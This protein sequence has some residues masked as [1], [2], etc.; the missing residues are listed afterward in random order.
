[1]GSTNNAA[2]I[3]R[4][5]AA[6]Y[7]MAIVFLSTD[8]SVPVVDGDISPEVLTEGVSGSTL[9]FS[10]DLGTPL[11]WLDRASCSWPTPLQLA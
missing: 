5:N 9:S 4:G 2:G 8:C 1:M 10:H 6:T 7:Q 11:S 3:Y